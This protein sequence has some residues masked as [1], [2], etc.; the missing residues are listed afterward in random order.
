MNKRYI[1]LDLLKRCLRFFA[2]RTPSYFDSYGRQEVMSKMAN[3]CG[4]EKFF[5]E[6]FGDVF[7]N[8]IVGGGTATATIR[9]S[10][11]TTSRDGFLFFAFAKQSNPATAL[12]GNS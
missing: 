9:G 12:G 3:R 5:M 1:L 10:I 4:I 8:S 11:T 2:R 6:Q 7:A